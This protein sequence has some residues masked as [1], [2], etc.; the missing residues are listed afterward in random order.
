MYLSSTTDQRRCRRGPTADRATSSQRVIGTPRARWTPR[1]SSSTRAMRPLCRPQPLRA[2]FE[3]SGLLDVQAVAIDVPPSSRTSTTFGAPSAARARHSATAP[4]CPRIAGTPP[5]PAAPRCCPAIP[6]GPSH[7]RPKQGPPADS[8][9]SDNRFA[10]E[11]TRAC[12][13]PR[14]PHSAGKTAP[15][16]K[17]SR[18][19]CSQVVAVTEQRS[20]A[21]VA[22]DPGSG[23]VG[24]SGLAEQTGCRPRARTHPKPITSAIIHPRQGECEADSIAHVVAT[25]AGLHITSS[26]VGYVAG[27]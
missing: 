17:A 11:A 3:A 15:K 12:R 23:G 20:R 14:H 16:V 26:S 19:T 6:T 25:W 5:Q 7:S 9:P 1:R 8:S 21:R 27:W 22:D 2:L 18:A 24:V 4:P 10:E 13:F